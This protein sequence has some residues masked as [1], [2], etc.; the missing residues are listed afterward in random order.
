MLPKDTT[1]IILDFLPSVAFTEGEKFTVLENDDLKNVEFLPITVHT[2]Q[3][4]PFVTDSIPPLPPHITSLI[5]PRTYPR[6][7][8]HLPFI[9]KVSMPP[10]SNTKLPP[11]IQELILSNIRD[12]SSLSVLFLNIVAW[13][14]P[15]LET[16]TIR[17]H[18]SK[19]ARKSL[20]KVKPRQ[21]QLIYVF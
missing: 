2:I 10:L 9:T 1:G 8:A 3:I 20:D 11:N 13:Q 18:F 4:A 15:L 16:I 14:Y 7:L 21:S 6:S 19:N 17:K 5:I 12:Y